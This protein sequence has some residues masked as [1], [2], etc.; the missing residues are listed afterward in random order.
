[1]REMVHEAIAGAREFLGEVV[2]DLRGEARL[3]DDELLARYEGQHRGRPWAMM[4]FAGSTL[5]QARPFDYAQGDGG[6][7]GDVLG[8]A[9]RYE[10]EMEK[11]RES[12]VKRQTSSQVGGV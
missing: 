4:E 9:L 8:E 12:N 10:A 7:G 5:R 2:G 11:L 3:S 1:M 6:G